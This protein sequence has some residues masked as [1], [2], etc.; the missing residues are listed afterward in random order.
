[1]EGMSETDEAGNSSSE[2]SITF[3]NCEGVNGVVT[4]TTSV[5]QSDTSIFLTS[6]QNG[7]YS[8]PDCTEIT[9]NNIETLATIERSIFDSIPVDGTIVEGNPFES[10]VFTI[11]GSISGVCNGQSFSCS[12]DSQPLL[13]GQ[14]VLN[15][16]S[17]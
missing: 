8:T 1:M 17:L 3:E 6:T 5:T 13:N 15:S 14:D 9:F 16:C 2:F 10:V 7:S 4:T 11:T 12:L